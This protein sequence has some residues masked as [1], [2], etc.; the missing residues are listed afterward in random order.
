VA[1][2]GPTMGAKDAI[3]VAFAGKNNAI[4]MLVDIDAV[5]VVDEA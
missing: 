3:N 2:S 1:G 5:K 4:A